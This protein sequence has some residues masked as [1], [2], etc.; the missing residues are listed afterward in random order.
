MA[1][2][3][4]LDSKTDDVVILG[5]TGRRVSLA[6]T[7]ATRQSLTKELGAGGPSMLAGMIVDDEE[8]NKKLRGLDGVKIFDKMRRSDAQVAAV[9]GAL[10][11]PILSAERVIDRPE[12]DEAAAER[13]T[14]EH[15]DFARDNLFR[16]I[17]FSE[18]LR[19]ALSAFWAGYSWFEKVY[20]AEDGKLVLAKLAP[21]MALTLWRW[22]TDDSGELTGIT[23]RVR[24]GGSQT[25]VLIPRNKVALFSVSKE[26][27]DV[28]GISLLRPAYKSYAIKDA[29][30]KLEA[31]RFERFAVGVPVITLPDEYTDDMRTM[32]TEIAK[33][34][35]GA[36]QS[37]A[38]MVGSMK[39]DLAQMGAQS[40]DI[41]PAIRHHNEEIAKSVLAQFI[42]LGTSETGSRALGDSMMEFF[43]D[44]IEGHAKA[45]ATQFNREVLWPT[46]DLN[47]SGKIR[48]E[49]RFE[50]IGSA[51]LS[52]LASGLASLRDFVN[53]DGDTENY[54]RR[55]LGLPQLL[56]T[57]V[58]TAPKREPVEPVQKQPGPT[59][60]P[61][62]TV[63]SAEHDHAVRL[64]ESGFWRELREPETYVKLRSIDARLEEGKEA[65]VEALMEFRDEI[66]DDLAKQIKA[67]WS[68]GPKG[69]SHVEIGTQ[70]VALAALSLEPELTALFE[71]GK[72][73]VDGELKRQAKKRGID[74]QR[75]RGNVRTSTILRDQ[76]LRCAPI[77][78]RLAE[79]LQLRDEGLTPSEIKELTK[80]RAGEMVTRLSR[81]TTEAAVAMAGDRWRTQG[82]TE[83]T[84]SV[85]DDI[86][87]EVFSSVEREAKLAANL[88]ASESLNL[89]RDFEFRRF[90]EQI[91]T[92]QYSAILDENGCPNCAAA[93]GEETDYG[94]EEYYDLLPPLNSSRFGAC[95]GGGAC[96]CIAVAVL[97]S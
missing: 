15:L 41:Q 39:L 64:S 12:D 73:Q 89:G 67:Q 92:I 91:E 31:I 85:L 47:F 75:K 48:P 97:R 68:A 55:R 37:F 76:I 74:L 40:L 59:M 63:A 19:H 54:I 84:G 56:L 32:A 80:F 52:Q 66:G 4:T 14:D 90:S 45:F 8:H 26:A 70:V 27:G 16:R 69:L 61:E 51:S 5:P 44:A 93:D 71:F 7:P 3:I 36:E 50:D 82:G 58:E 10:Q 11:L 1:T 62:P 95:L 96:R 49:L 53:W 35:R 38:I 6:A 29:L 60:S 77:D 86:M 88:T 43:Y 2:T 21:R 18:A 28:G 20:A 9:M 42:N 57:G 72:D 65:I 30:Y 87:E 17:D 78:L 25:D 23:Q 79:A 81:K 46:M 24:R 22:E 33:N 13:I 83:P 94:S 34:W